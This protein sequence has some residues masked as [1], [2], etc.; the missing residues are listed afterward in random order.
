[1]KAPTMPTT[2]SVI[3]P[4]PPPRTNCEAS[5]PETSPTKSQMI[6][7]S[8]VM[9]ASCARRE[10][11][12]APGSETMNQMLPGRGTRGRRAQTCPVRHFANRAT[13]DSPIGRDQVGSGAAIGEGGRRLE[14]RLDIDREYDGIADG[15]RC[16]TLAASPGGA[17][18]RS[19]ADLDP[20]HEANLLVV[21]RELPE[22][23]HRQQI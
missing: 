13:S 16:D 4:E 2:M 10:P 3:A 9:P 11:G 23:R 22:Q 7:V 12:R 5:Q 18:P 1:M 17:G 21:E 14:Q 20:E 19:T 6:A 15:H 8:M